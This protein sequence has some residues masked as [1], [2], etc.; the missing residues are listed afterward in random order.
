MPLVTNQTKIVDLR[1]ANYIPGIVAA[2]ADYSAGDMVQVEEA[3]AFVLTDV[4]TGVNMAF[5][6]KADQVRCLKA[7]E[8]IDAGDDIYYDLSEELFT[9]VSTDNVKLGTALEDAALGD[10]TL[11]MTFD[12]RAKTLV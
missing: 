4:L 1:S 2:A 5:I 10:D 9:K 12:G 8:A 3:A 6:I 11:L 7:S